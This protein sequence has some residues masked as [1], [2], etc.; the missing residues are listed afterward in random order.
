MYSNEQTYMLNDSMN[1]EKHIKTYLLSTCVI[2][3]NINL[4]KNKT[5]SNYVYWPYTSSNYIQF[6]QANLY[7]QRNNMVMTM[8]RQKCNSQEYI[9]AR[10][11]EKGK[12]YMTVGEFDTPC[13]NTTTLR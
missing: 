3:E 13:T 8:P 2:I 10:M 9:L 11:Y 7:L 4:R 12:S 1:I 5:T 6:N